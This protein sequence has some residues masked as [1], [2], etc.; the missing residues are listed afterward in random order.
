VT[1]ARLAVRHAI[2]AVLDVVMLIGFVALETPGASTGFKYHE[3][4]GIAFAVLFV[5]HLAYSWSWITGT[6]NRVRRGPDPRVRVNFV[7]NT[8]LFSMMLVA[9]ISGFA[10]SDYV[11]PSAHLPTSADPRWR[12]VHN[13]TASFLIVVVGLHLAINWSWIKGA[14]RRYVGASLSRDGRG[15]IAS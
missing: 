10:V 15:E 6:V 3:W 13:M 11:L 12:N 4:V 9:V 1:S 5:A 2:V 8:V 7:L 14:Y